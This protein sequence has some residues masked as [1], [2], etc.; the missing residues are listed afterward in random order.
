MFERVKRWIIPVAGAALM[1]VLA[2]MIL[3]VFWDVTRE[4]AAVPPT[5]VPNVEALDLSAPDGEHKGRPAYAV[6]FYLV[7]RGHYYPAWLIEVDGN[8]YLAMHD[9]IRVYPLGGEPWPQE[10]R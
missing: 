4:N 3:W 1:L 2:G 7:H 6:D 8:T 9:G 10:R 5:P